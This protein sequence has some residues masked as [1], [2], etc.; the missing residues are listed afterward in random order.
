[1]LHGFWSLFDLALAEMI[2]AGTVAATIV[3]LAFI[4]CFGRQSP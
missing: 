2:L 4:I 3:V 1:V